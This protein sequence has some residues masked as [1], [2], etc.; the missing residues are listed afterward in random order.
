MATSNDIAVRAT[1]DRLIDLLGIGETYPL[2]DVEVQQAQIVSYSVTCTFAIDPGQTGVTYE[3]YEGNQPVLVDGKVLSVDGLGY[4]ETTELPSPLITA[5]K[6]FRIHAVKKSWP[7]RP[8]GPARDS[9]LFQTAK[10]T[11]GLN[12]GL[13]VKMEPRIADY[14]SN[15]T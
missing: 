1:R 11:V 14:G 10:V 8:D 15:V 12:K 2:Q 9:F 5:D 4:D 7:G 6:T 3:L 13:A